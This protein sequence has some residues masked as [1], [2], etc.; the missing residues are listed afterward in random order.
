MQPAHRYALVVDDHPLIRDGLI[1]TLER[2]GLRLSCDGAAD[3]ARA[4]RALA[5]ATRYDLVLADQ[6]LPDGDGLALLTEAA[7]AHPRTALVLLSGADDQRLAAQARQAGLA[8]Y[9]SKSL[10]PAQMVAAIERVLAGGSWFPERTR[11]AAPA[12]TE[13]QLD[14][15]QRICA[16]Q[17]SKTIA[18]ELGVGER[19]VKDHLT[20]IYLRLGA[21][22]RAEAVAK[23]SA[24]GL[25]RIEA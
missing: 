12:F 17:P 10:E 2:S 13:R 8:G 15:L 3:V 20:V 19:T 4:R 6:R 11:T 18:L 24:L 14:V 25:V 22:N 1:A 5:G 9:L 21:S 16:G 23:A 7:V